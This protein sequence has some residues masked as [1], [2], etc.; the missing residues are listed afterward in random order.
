MA[1]VGEPTQYG[2]AERLMRTIKE[3]EVDLSEYRDYHDVY[4]HIGQFRN[5]AKRARAVLF[6]W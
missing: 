3:E 4:Q 1:E 5:P 6:S 2:Y